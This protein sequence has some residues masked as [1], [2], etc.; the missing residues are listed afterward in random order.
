MSSE[1]TL[2]RR[3]PALRF[4]PLWRP[5]APCVPWSTLGKRRGGNAFGPQRKLDSSED[6]NNERLFLPLYLF[7]K[8]DVVHV[9]ARHQEPREF[10]LLAALAQAPKAGGITRGAFPSGVGFRRSATFDLACVSVSWCGRY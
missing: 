1:A 4:V 7:S 10:R 6:I 5:P 9:H 2:S 3:P 8:Q